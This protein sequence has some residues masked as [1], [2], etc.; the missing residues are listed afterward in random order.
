MGNLRTKTENIILVFST[1]LG[2][3]L[4]VFYLAAY[5]AIF[6]LLFTVLSE[7][8]STFTILFIAAA[9]VVLEYLRSNLFTGFGWALLG[10]S[11][12]LNLPLIQ[13]A[14]LG[15]VYLVS[16]LVMVINIVTYLIIRRERKYLLFPLLFILV[17]LAYGYFKI[18]NLKEPGGVESWKVSVIQGNIP[19]EL[20]WDPEAKSYII[21]N[22]F[23]LT[24]EAL[25]DKPDLIIWPEA[26]LPFVLEEDPVH[27]ERVINFAKE[28][29]TSLLLGAVRQKEGAYFNSAILVPLEESPQVY[30][31]LHLVPFGEY[32]PLKNI[33]KFLETVVPIGDFLEGSDYVIFS[34]RPKFAVLICF[35]DIFPQIARQFV[36]RGARILINITNDAWFKE[37]SCPFQHL[38]ASVL[39]AVENRVCLI[40]CANSGVSGFIDAKGNIFSRVS[41]NQGKEIFI[42]GYLTENIQVKKTKSIYTK[43]GD[44]FVLFTALLV[45]YAI[46]FKH[47][48]FSKL[49]KKDGKI[50]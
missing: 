36:K 10:Y 43:Y 12:Y 9:W 42:R 8:L 2:F 50:K 16:F 14:D 41:D 46:M 34:S 25:S 11:Q 49:F 27:Y 40:R 44:F 26:A 21:E 19:Q 6:G 39:R 3:L 13:I 31:K 1:F 20:K 17:S 32:I 18:Y 37:T 38:Q 48:L 28:I 29:K 24:R 15:G 4:L 30:D 22:Y 5:F 7:R 45:V 33:F 23:N 35:E 47:R